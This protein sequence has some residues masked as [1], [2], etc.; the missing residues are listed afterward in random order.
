V[1]NQEIELRFMS[2]ADIPQVL[3]V[4]HAAFTMP[5]TETAFRNELLNNHFAK[6]IVAEQQGRIIGYCGV[7]V[8]ID[9][10]HITNVAVHPEYQGQKIGWELM[11]SIIYLAQQSGAV[12]MTLEVRISNERAQSL[13]HKLGFEIQGIRK[14][15]YS[16]NQED[17]YIMWANLDGV[18]QNDG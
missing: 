3:K 5:W 16:D 18:E 14:K 1:S 10:A 13:Y 11:Q 7:W 17:A 9:E 6:Y 8:I 12:R 15:Y 4:E 2:V